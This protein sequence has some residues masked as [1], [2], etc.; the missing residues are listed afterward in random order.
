VDNVAFVE[1]FGALEELDEDLAGF[2]FGE[3]LLCDNEI[4]EFSFCCK[5]QY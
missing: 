4:E 2:L 5:L 1:V 3:L